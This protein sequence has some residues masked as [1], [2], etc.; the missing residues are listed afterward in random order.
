[1]SRKS[2]AAVWPW[3]GQGAIQLD[4]RLRPY[5]HSHDRASARRCCRFFCLDERLR[6]YRRPLAIASGYLPTR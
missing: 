6:H 1:M 5:P 3:S 2:A 4:E